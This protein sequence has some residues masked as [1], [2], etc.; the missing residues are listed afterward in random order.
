MA[1]TRSETEVAIVGSGA[2]ALWLARR[3]AI[4]RVGCSII[5]QVPLA[6]FASTRNQGW[7]QSGAFYAATDH[8]DVARDC[9]RGNETIREFCPEAVGD[10]EAFFL[11]TEGGQM[12]KFLKLCDEQQI[13]ASGIS[14]AYAI[15][16][17]P[18]LAGSPFVA[19]AWASDCSIDSRLVLSRLVDQS[20]EA[21]V[22]FLKVGD[23]SQV[24]FEQRL[25]QWAIKGPAWSLKA[26]VLILACGAYTPR[27][28]QTIAPGEDEKFIITKV[29]VLV[30][31]Q[32]VASRLL[33]APYIE[34]GPNLVPFHLGDVA[35]FTVCLS[36][37]DKSITEPSDSYPTRREEKAYRDAL[38]RWYPN[39]QQY[40]GK[41]YG[42][43]GCQKMQYHPSV[44]RLESV[45]RAIVVEHD[46]SGSGGGR[47]ITFYPGKLTS[48]PI[49][50]E[51]CWSVIRNGCRVDTLSP[52]NATDP[53]PEVEEPRAITI[54]LD[55]E[56]DWPNAE[57][58]RQRSGA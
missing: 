11:F 5:D 14:M 52:P 23:L 18:L 29:P 41:P 16:N 32:T 26:R 6:G 35:G 57:D 34:A 33:V 51:E 24:R 3:L 58:G 37:V 19:A 2:A 43:Y 13:S 54:A 27:L 40:R 49:G 21:G 8:P 55:R 47:L 20:F 30:M 39:I 56:L 22:R 7:F 10:N 15:E 4:E 9:A 50:A 46:V 44:A 12:N 53:P 31:H 25:G 36:D 42:V 1:E 17:E 48:A 28:L 38:R 45:R